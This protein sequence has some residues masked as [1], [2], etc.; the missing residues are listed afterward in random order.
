M[1]TYQPVR[2]A[3]RGRRP[4]GL[5]FARR[6]ASYMMLSRGQRTLYLSLGVAMLIATSEGL[7][8][9]AIWLS[10]PFLDEQIRTTRDIFREQSMRIELLIRPDSSRML[11]VDSVLGWRYRAGHHDPDN[12]INA[13][14]V[15]STR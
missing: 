10:G 6:R 7:S 3:A 11:D 2:A 13:Q 15:R 4:T 9:L 5:G 1:Y 8:L 12:T 14:G